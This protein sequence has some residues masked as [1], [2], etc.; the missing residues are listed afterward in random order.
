MQTLAS[1]ILFLTATALSGADPITFDNLPLGSEE[2]PLILRTYMPDPDLADAYFAHHGKSSNSPKYNPGTGMDVK[3]EFIPIKGLPAA[4][5]VNHGPALSYAFDA[6]E[7]RIAYAWQGGFLDMYPYWGDPVRG[8]RLSYDYVPRLVGILFHKAD[9][10]SEIFVDGKRMTELDDPKFTGYDLEKGVPVFLFSR[11]GHEFRLKVMPEA[12]T[13]LS[14]KFT[15]SSPDK[16]GITYG[17]PSGD[18]TT[19]SLTRTVTGAKLATFQGYPR[20]MNIKEATIANGQL[21]FDNLGCSA[22]HSVDGSLGHGP[23]LAGLY[24]NERQV[25][26]TKEPVMADEAYIL[27]SIKTPGAKT[28]K[29]FP[30]N[31][32]P[33]YVLKDL[34]YKSLVLFVESVAKGE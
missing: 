32:M 22:C 27:E 34:E 2:K 7:C 6:I 30:P 1:A 24:G 10:M 3:G 4:I 31:Y 13:P 16:L 26:E 5:G 29:G 11:G 8:N 23:T 15:L 28:A 18:K 12:G 14:F 33:P 21:L 19:N 25:E 17:T 20:D 9:P